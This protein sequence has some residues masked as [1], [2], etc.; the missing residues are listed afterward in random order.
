M[1]RYELLGELAVGG[2]A[3]ILLG[4]LVGPGGFERPV[5]IK[6]I[7]PHL[8][9]QKAFFDMF[10]DEARIAASI[11]HHNV[12]H[13]QELVHEGDELFLVMEYLEGESVA[14]LARRLVNR[15]EPLPMALGGYIVA[16]ACAGLHASHELLAPGGAKQ[17]L[18]HRD[19]TPQN[20]FVTY[21]G[22]VKI[23]DYGIAKAAD[24][25][26]RTEAGQVK[27]KFEYMSP[28]QCKGEPLD[29]R[30]DI[31]ALGILLYELTTGRRLFKSATPLEAV[32][33]ICRDS[34]VPPSRL[35]DDYPRALEQVCLRALS[36][37]REDRYPTSAEMRRAILACMRATQPVEEPGEQLA[38]LMRSLFVDR[39]EEKA[40]MLRQLSVGSDVSHIPA[41][42]VD[43]GV[44]PPGI[45]AKVTTVWQAELSMARSSGATPL[46]QGPVRRFWA[47]A[48]LAVVSAGLAAAVV[49]IAARASWPRRP[50]PSAIPAPVVTAGP[51]FE[52]SDAAPLAVTIHIETRPPGATVWLDGERKGTTP[53]DLR[54][55]HDERPLRLELRS[56]GY[57]SATER[58]V[59][60]VDQKIY[61]ELHLA[62]TPRASGAGAR[63]SAPPPSASPWTKWN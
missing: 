24:G 2:M 63:R 39:L 60:D 34:I 45:P 36:A 30:S 32:K 51:A 37:S 8:A 31:F 22:Q 53:I 40:Q 27:G 19:V 10:L 15:A 59:A 33:A 29:R 28:E 56:A 58:L 43:Q 20:V 48:A 52:A 62:A 4:R 25:S 1:G 49:T 16:E 12:V 13:V 41:G 38:T 46:A 21:D 17:N 35:V 9:R 26:S 50:P 18:V 57:A 55:P 54:L 44:E 11:R 47:R 7:L 5:V 42:E 6:R 3:E 23:L 61:V 14:G